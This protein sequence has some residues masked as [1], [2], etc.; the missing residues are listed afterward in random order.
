MR[1]LSV[2]RPGAPTSRLCSIAQSL[3]LLLPHV[4]AIDDID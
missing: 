3:I 2:C 4:P 1:T